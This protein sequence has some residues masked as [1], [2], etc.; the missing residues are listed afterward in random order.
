MKMAKKLGLAKRFG[1]RYGAS[2]KQKFAE[3]EIEQR[4]K[5]KCPFC[6]SFQVKRLALGIWN[7]RKCKAKFTGKAYTIKE[8]V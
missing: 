5:H 4:K 6:S 3:I 1:P 7:C 2:I 8:G